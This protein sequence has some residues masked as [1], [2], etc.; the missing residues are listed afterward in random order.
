MACAG[1]RMEGDDAKAKLA[2]YEALLDYPHACYTMDTMRAVTRA[3]GVKGGFFPSLGELQ[4]I[5]D[6]E[7]ARLECELERCRAVIGHGASTQPHGQPGQMA[8]N[9]HGTGEQWKF[10]LERFQD[11]AFW[12]ESTWGGRPGTGTCL[13]P[14]ATIR[15]VLGDM[16]AEA[17]AGGRRDGGRKGRTPE[18]IE[19]VAHLLKQW[20]ST[21]RS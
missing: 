17:E 11:S 4:L 1:G 8:G 19:E 21:G 18:Q 2:V 14:L 5:L 6:R 13:A 16:T 20:R 9:A 15:L 7:R 10:R 12:V 3:M